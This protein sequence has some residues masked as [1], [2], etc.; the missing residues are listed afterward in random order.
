MR[1][2]CIL[3]GAVFTD[4]A[5]AGARSSEREKG[6]QLT[7]GRAG[8]AGD[9]VGAALWLASDASAWVTVCCSAWTAALPQMS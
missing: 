6:P 1:V 7:A 9:F 5:D 2:N 3:P 4:I 8:Q